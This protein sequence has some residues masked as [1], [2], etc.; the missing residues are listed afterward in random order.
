M[1]ARLAPTAYIHRPRSNLARCRGGLV[2]ALLVSASWAA[3]GPAGRAD[4]KPADA[5]AAKPAAPADAGQA[6]TAAP[7]KDAALLKDATRL[8]GLIPLYRKDDKLHAELSDALL[9]KEFFVLTSISR[10]I[11]ERCSGA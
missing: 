1:A 2:A 11:G 8:P 4:D 10:G 6:A 5:A 3:G 9:G 7:P